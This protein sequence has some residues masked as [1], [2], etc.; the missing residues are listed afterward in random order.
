MVADGLRLDQARGV[1]GLLHT[2]AVMGGGCVPAKDGLDQALRASVKHGT[3]RRSSRCWLTLACLSGMMDQD[4]PT[5]GP[6]DKY[7]GGYALNNLDRTLPTDRNGFDDTVDREHRACMRA[8]SPNGDV[9]ATRRQDGLPGGA[10]RI[11]T[12]MT[13]PAGMHADDLLV[14]SPQRHHG[15]EVASTHR[16]VEGLFNRF[17]TERGL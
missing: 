8:D 7:I 3:A 10:D 2:V 6:F 11:D 16:V 4:L 9:N 13:R 14:V 12:D 5:R 1:V 15:G 17:G